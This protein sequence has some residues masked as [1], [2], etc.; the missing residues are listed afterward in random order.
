MPRSRAPHS[1]SRVC[2]NNARGWRIPAEATRPRVGLWRRRAP[3]LPPPL[4]RAAPS[5]Q[6]RLAAARQGGGAEEITRR[7]PTRSNSNSADARAAPCS[8]PPCFSEPGRRAC[9]ARFLASAFPGGRYVTSLRRRSPRSPPRVVGVATRRPPARTMPRNARAPATLGEGRCGSAR[10]ARARPAETTPRES[11]RPPPGA[12]AFVVPVMSAHS[13]SNPAPNNAWDAEP[14]TSPTSPQSSSPGAPQNEEDEENEEDRRPRYRRSKLLLTRRVYSMRLPRARGGATK[15][16]FSSPLSTPAPAPQEAP[17]LPPV[18]PAH[19]APFRPEYYLEESPT[20]PAYFFV[21][22]ILPFP[23]RRRSGDPPSRYL[24]LHY[25]MV[26]P[27]SPHAH[28]CANPRA[29]RQVKRW[30]ANA[31]RW[32]VLHKDFRPVIQLAA[33]RLVAVP[34]GFEPYPERTEQS[35]PDVLSSSLFAPAWTK[36]ESTSAVQVPLPLSPLLIADGASTAR[37]LSRS[38]RVIVIGDVH[39]CIDEFQALLRLSDYRP[40]DQVILLGDLVA[41]GPDSVGVVQMAR[42][43]GARTVRGTHFR[44][45]CRPLCPSRP[46]GPVCS[47]PPFPPPLSVRAVPAGNHDH[48]TCQASPLFRPA[49]PV[50]CRRNH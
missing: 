48:G 41:K 15:A 16:P 31:I 10:R 5:R 11:A 28:D 23:P 12:P 20:V 8:R 4:R 2:I 13:R 44:S 35:D 29:S 39:G 42:D 34:P 3:H 17:P 24:E 27:A 37:A 21:R 47:H 25:G 7:S 14:S 33:D 1:V 32:R 18:A 38:P 45:S 6:S 9:T 49:H 19:P 43:I 26:D 22:G 50:S 46:A 36:A 40:G 30:Y